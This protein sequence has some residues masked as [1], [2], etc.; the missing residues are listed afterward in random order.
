MGPPV[1]SPGLR[2]WRPPSGSCPAEPRWPCGWEGAGAAGGR[3][4]ART[5]RHVPQG[6]EPGFVPSWHRDMVPSRLGDPTASAGHVVLLADCRRPRC[7]EQVRGGPPRSAQRTLQAQGPRSRVRCGGLMA[8]VQT[9]P[10]QGRALC[11]ASPPVPKPR[12]G[13][14]AS[15]RG[16]RG[17]GQPPSLSLVRAAESGSAGTGR[18]LSTACAGEAGRGVPPAAGTARPLC[19]MGVG[20][21]HTPR[22]Q[23]PLPFPA[24]D[25][26]HL[27][28]LFASAPH[29]LQWRGEGQNSAEGRG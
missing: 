8:Q 9:C 3:G 19:G 4:S 25:T 16:L 26:A 23:M 6:P 18:D 2:A 11:P 1:L 24:A 28:P 15:R 14:A 10:L 29:L 22:M 21:S 17:H 5:P 12:P 13:A 27:S 7:G 20:L